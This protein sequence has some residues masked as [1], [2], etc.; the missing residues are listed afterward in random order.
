M[1]FASLLSSVSE[2]KCESSRLVVRMSSV[3]A[4]GLPCL[5]HACMNHIDDVISLAISGENSTSLFHPR[6]TRQ[7]WNVTSS[8]PNT[9]PTSEQ[10]KAHLSW[11][12]WHKKSRFTRPRDVIDTMERLMSIPS[13][14]RFVGAEP[15][16]H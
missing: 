4:P 15:G 13:I 7:P 10:N 2:Q 3:R 14:L 12:N 1:K 11:V 9:R 8:S 6:A 16:S 5:S